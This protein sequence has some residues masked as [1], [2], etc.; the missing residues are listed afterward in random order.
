VDDSTRDR[1]D[2]G[3]PRTGPGRP[4]Q[5]ADDDEGEVD[6]EADEDVDEEEEDDDPDD[7]PDVEAAAGVED[8]L[9]EP[10]D[11]DDPEPAVTVPEPDL[12]RESVR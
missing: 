3:P 2:P 10:D 12:P 11:E 9:S 5:A 8:P 6:E 7:S 1:A 4:A